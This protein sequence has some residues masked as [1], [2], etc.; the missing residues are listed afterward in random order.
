MA[1]IFFRFQFV[2]APDCFFSVSSGFQKIR[3]PQNFVIVANQ[4]KNMTKST[5][6]FLN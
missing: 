4:K 3:Y 6:I 2:F 1:I 5:I